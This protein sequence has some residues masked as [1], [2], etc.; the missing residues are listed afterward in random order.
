[1]SSKSALSWIQDL[2]NRC[3]SCAHVVCAIVLMCHEYLMSS[4][5][6]NPMKDFQ[7]TNV[8]TGPGIK[9]RA[10]ECTYSML[11]VKEGVKPSSLFAI[12][13]QSHIF[14]HLCIVSHKWDLGKQGRPRSDAA[15]RSKTKLEKEY[16]MFLH[17]K[18]TCPIESTRH[19]RV[20]QQ[21][22]VS[23]DWMVG[24]TQSL[25]IPGP[26]MGSTQSLA[27]PDP[28]MGSTQSLV[29]PGPMVGSTRSLVSPGPMVG[30][31]QSL[32]SPGP[33]VG[34][35]QSLVS[36]SPHGICCLYTEVEKWLSSESGE[37]DKK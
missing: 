8:P 27:S 18:W 12:F 35:T 10:H 13:P 32:V 2:G 29:S 16:K 20:N 25:A 15:K 22:L 14:N 30:S 7:R 28:M 34:S 6:G 36:P 9:S 5:A 4:K 21:S 33:M 3:Y 1:M 11:K 19:K 26:M 37:S 31:T 23:P 24:S 17:E